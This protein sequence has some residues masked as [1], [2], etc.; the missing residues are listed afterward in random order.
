MTLGEY[1]ENDGEDN[2]ELICPE[3]INRHHLGIPAFTCEAKQLLRGALRVLF[4]D[5]MLGC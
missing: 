1:G 4:K 2:G 3:N 5:N